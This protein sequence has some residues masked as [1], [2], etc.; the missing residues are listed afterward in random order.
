MIL[1]CISYVCWHLILCLALLLHLCSSFPYFR[2]TKLARN[3]MLRVFDMMRWSFAALNE[4]KWPAV[5]WLGDPIDYSKRMGE[6]WAE[7]CFKFAVLWSLW[8]WGAG[9]LPKSYVSLMSL[10]NIMPHPQ[11]GRERPRWRLVCDHICSN[12]GQRL[13]ARCPQHDQYQHWP[14]QLLP[15]QQR[16]LSMVRLL[17]A[18]QVDA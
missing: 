13:Q 18:C 12:W 16:G 4:G 10:M 15:L 2:C 6:V 1:W 7:F 14:M 8:V 5:D 3:T 11:A 9:T 17:L